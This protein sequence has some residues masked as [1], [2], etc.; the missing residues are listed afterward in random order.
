MENFNH[1]PKELY[2]NIAK[3]ISHPTA[4]VI[5]P[6]MKTHPTAKRMHQVIRD[7]HDY[8][9]LLQEEYLEAYGK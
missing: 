6:Y 8:T 9:G 4:N 3:Y 5:R 1:L 7:V 2:W